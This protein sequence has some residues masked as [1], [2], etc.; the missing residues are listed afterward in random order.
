MFQKLSTFS[1]VVVWMKGEIAS[2]SIHFK[3]KESVRT[4]EYKTKTLEWASIFFFVLVNEDG[5]HGRGLA[6][7][8]L[9]GLKRVFD[10]LCLSD[11]SV[12]T[13]GLTIEI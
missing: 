13:V 2:K 11:G 12:W 1:S 6:C 7:L 5:Y 10:L 8:S 4:G 3:R 9:S